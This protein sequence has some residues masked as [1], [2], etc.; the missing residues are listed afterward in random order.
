MFKSPALI[1]RFAISK[2]SFVNSPSI[3]AF[4]WRLN[5][6]IG[7]GPGA[8]F[9]HFR[10]I[11]TTQYNTWS[12]H[13]FFIDTLCDSGLFGAISLISMILFAIYLVIKN[14]N[15]EFILV[16]GVILIFMVAHSMIEINFIYAPYMITLGLVL[17]MISSNSDEKLS[18][19]GIDNNFV[20]I[21]VLS[22][23]NV[24]FNVM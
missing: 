19:G 18:K 21:L 6:L 10:D 14:R 20:I 24:V 23:I 7:K 15:N 12:S 9:I 22:L 11:Q 3:R 1:V 5:P 4:I 17:G 16:L 2:S 13:N 8:F